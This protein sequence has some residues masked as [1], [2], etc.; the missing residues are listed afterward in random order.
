VIRRDE[1]ERPTALR[2]MQSLASRISPFA[3]WRHSGDAAWAVTLLA[4]A[5]HCPSSVWSEDGETRA[6]ALFETPEEL[7]VQV[8]P[9]LPGLA[10][11][12]LAWAEQ[13]ASAP[14]LSV[15]ISEVEKHV[16]DALR[17]R[18]YT[19]AA[20]GPFFAVLRHDLKA[21]PP[22]PALPAGYTIRSVGDDDLAA[23]ADVHRAVWNNDKITPQRH[24]AMRATWPYKPEFDLMAVGPDGGAAAYVQGWYDEHSRVGLFEPVGTRTEHRRLGLSR[25]L[26]LAVLHAFAAAGARIATV[27]PRGD[28]A[29]PVPKLVYESIGFRAYSR[30]HTYVK[31]LSQ[32]P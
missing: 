32:E 22:V 21:L 24:R 15:T 2:A 28:A 19:E 31:R 29:Y 16:T 3:S 26:G 14:E 11:A 1:Y 25:T 4:E 13:T 5:D 6:W 18:G 27:N 10:D 7:T 23:R 17:A 12:V 20:D 30:S 8:D 9:A